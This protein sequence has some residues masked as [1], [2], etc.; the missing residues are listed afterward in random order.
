M[1]QPDSALDKSIIDPENL[2]ASLLTLVLRASVSV[3]LITYLASVYFALKFG[4]GFVVL[5]DTIGISLVFALFLF[6]R[7]HLLPFWVRAIATCLTFYFIGLGLLIT[8]GWIG[9]IYL[10]CSSILATLLLG[11]ELGFGASLL[12]SLSLLAVG[13]LGIWTPDMQ[14][15]IGRYGF[16]DW[17]VMTLNF[18]LVDFLIT[19]AIGLVLRAV[20]KALK[21]ASISQTE[22]DDERAV[23]RAIIDTLPDVIFTK[24]IQGR[25]VNCNPATLALFGLES[26]SQVAGK[27]VFELFASREIAEAYHTDDL[28]VMTGQ[29]L[30]NREE[31]SVDSKGNQIWYLT[32][33]VP[34]YNASGD[35]IGLVG[36]S[37]DITDRKRAEAS[38]NRA[39]VQLQL[40]IERMPL[41]Y[42]MTDNN[43]RFIRWNPAAEK[44]FGYTQAEILGKTPFETIVPVESQAFVAE[45]FD[46]IKLGNM[47]AH[48][49][50]ANKTKNGVA[51]SCEWFNTPL[52]DDDGAFAG[53]LSLTQDIT[54]R[55]NLEDQLRQSQKLEAIGQL[56]GGVAHDFNNILAV[57][58]MQVNSSMRSINKNSE[59]ENEHLYE[60]FQQINEAVNR[61]KNLTQQLLAFSRKQVIQPKNIELNTIVREME[62]MLCRIIEENINLELDLDKTAKCIK[63]DPVHIEQIIMNLVVNSR[64]AMPSGG[65]I[66][67]KT[68][69][70]FID[71]EGPYT[72][73]RISDTGTG[74]SEETQKHMFDPFYTTKGVGKGTGLGLSTVY[75]IVKQNKGIISVESKINIGTT[76]KVYFP[77]SDEPTQPTSL[78]RAATE[79]A[80]GS[81]T[82]L[83][84]EDEE[85]LRKLICKILRSS[86]YTIYE[87]CDGLEA[88]DFL[89]YY[90]KPIHL[91]LTD[92][93]MPKMGG[94]ELFEISKTISDDFKF[95]FISGYTEDVVLQQGINSG[96]FHFLAKPFSIEA[97]LGKVRNV[98]EPKNDQNS[99]FISSNEP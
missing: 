14:I 61:A 84:V 62:K 90:Q 68:E 2:Q 63:A 16:T 74:M 83:V 4:L 30:F 1:A 17:A 36:I 54:N 9:Q 72:L 23:L 22:L 39:L 43:F 45:M 26:E 28:A 3:G 91:V 58:L 79:D 57:I 44:I 19:L 38:L 88:M 37:R 66:I 76:F 92:M 80:R 97:L 73:L 41:A 53:L 29:R 27:T 99:E 8:V 34:L 69:C 47:D 59:F 77:P 6:D 50:A 78:T 5:V 40:Q 75:G 60:S 71:G 94:R 10:I 85:N 81:E 21:K 13:T 87:A 18:T 48:G 82:I 12:C 55:K 31:K 49:E 35:V 95:L 25:F 24:D 64:D 7:Y 96:Q 52:F 20:N 70:A 46:K 65:K 42:L 56:A 98:L 15:P 67:I 86:G 89:K 51:I 33:K 32:I 93:V 11:I